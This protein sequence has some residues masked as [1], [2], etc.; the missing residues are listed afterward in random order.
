MTGDLGYRDK[1]GSYYFSDR[2]KDLIIKAGVNI[3]PGEVEEI[4]Y[5]IKE[6]KSA[7]V[8]GKE[9]KWY[10]MYFFYFLGFLN[11]KFFFI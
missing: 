4:L 2:V 3:F 9:D 11:F 1:N 6:V 7:A 8:L 10:Y 5:T